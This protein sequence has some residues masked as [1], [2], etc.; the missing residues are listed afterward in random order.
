MRRF[1][2]FFTIINKKKNFEKL[3]LECRNQFENATQKTFYLSYRVFWWDRIGLN[4]SDRKKK[5]FFVV[6]S[7]RS[8]SEMKYPVELIIAGNVMSV[9]LLNGLKRNVG[10]LRHARK[11]LAGFRFKKV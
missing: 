4:L 8:E 11:C 10:S 7:L 1:I 3:L 9:L 5:P 6:K 2:S